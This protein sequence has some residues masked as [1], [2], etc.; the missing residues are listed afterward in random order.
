M[1]F[2]SENIVYYAVKSEF[3]ENKNAIFTIPNKEV[4]IYYVGLISTTNKQLEKPLL[5]E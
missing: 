5:V 4:K 1:N 2:F 3:T